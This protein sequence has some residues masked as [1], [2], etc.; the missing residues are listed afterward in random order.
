MALAMPKSVD[1]GRAAGEQDV[2]GLD[3]AV[4]DAARRARTRALAARREGSARRRRPAGAVRVQ[5]SAQ[6]LALD[7]RHG[8]EGHAVGFTGGQHR[9]DVRVLQPRRQLDLTP[10]PLAAD[11]GR[12]LGGQHLDH[13]T[14]MEGHFFGQE[15]LRHAATAQLPLDAVAVTEGALQTFKQACHSVP[16]RG[17]M[18]SPECTAGPAGIPAWPRGVCARSRA[19]YTSSPPQRAGSTSTMVCVSVHEWPAGSRSTACRSPKG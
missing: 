10:E 14:A 9:H 11:L 17:G 16:S 15:H 19:A 18:I 6:R 5:P 12:H 4:H 3:V 13:H 8:V 2:V 1:A 7:E